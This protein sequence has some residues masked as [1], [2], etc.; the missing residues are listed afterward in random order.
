M[1]KLSSMQ[2]T[3]ARP[4]MLDY[5][6]FSYDFQAPLGAFGDIRPSYHKYRLLHL[7]LNDFGS[8]LAPLPHVM[9]V[10]P[11]LRNLNDADTPRLV[12][13][14]NPQGGFVFFNN[15]D[16]YNLAIHDL[17][18][19]TVSV[20]MEGEKL[21]FPSQPLALPARSYGI[22]PVNL[23]VEG[24][25]IKYST[26]QLICQLSPAGTDS[27]TT[28]FFFEID[29]IPAEFCIDGTSVDNVLVS[30]GQL[31][32]SEESGRYV[33]SEL[34]P[35][36]GCTITVQAAGQDKVR[37]I[38]L[39][40]QEAE[41]LW[42]ANLGG[43]ERVIISS[44]NL[45]FDGEQVEIF[46]HNLEKFA[47][48]II[49]P[50]PSCAKLHCAETGAFASVSD[51]GDFAQYN[52]EDTPDAKNIQV[53]VQETEIRGSTKSLVIALPP[54]AFDGV[55]DV[56]L[57]VDYV[58]DAIKL[59]VNDEF[60]WDEYYFGRPVQ[61]GLKRWVPAVL[62]SPLRIEITPLEKDGEIFLEKWPQF[63]PGESQIAAIRSIVAV[64][65]YKRT[66]HIIQ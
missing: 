54:D 59:Y 15:Y 1:G 2:E 14:M 63:P 60:V 8:R 34:Q 13:R 43:C 25:I 16:R 17:E 5:P 33:I 64:P 50:L 65:E 37:L 28:L 20:D 55:E 23:A 62:E 40:C 53:D 57:D 32:Q 7:F 51:V 48:I 66:I 31:T 11:R 18:D 36:L 41:D 52:L 46:T 35:G 58:G 12:A 6:V 30:K 47:L 61:I 27:A 39:A 21:S 9:P 19:V 49:P 56:F 38:T 44:A 4:A 45:V 22:W 3:L 26:A 10:E 42:K 29:G 24:V